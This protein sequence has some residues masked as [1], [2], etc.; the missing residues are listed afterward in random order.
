M[1]QTV[2]GV[3]FEVKHSLKKGKPT[4]KMAANRIAVVR[5][6][7]ALVTLFLLTVQLSGRILSASSVWELRSQHLPCADSSKLTLN[8]IN[9]FR[10]NWQLASK[11]IILSLMSPLWNGR[12]LNG[13][14]TGCGKAVFFLDKEVTSDGSHSVLIKVFKHARMQRFPVLT[15]PSSNSSSLHTPPT[16]PRTGFC[17][18]FP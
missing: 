18:P 10:L 2:E 5:A 6:W 15:P 17:I 16:W 11:V 4:Y 3:E 1:L 12:R 9:K 8:E 13:N 7:Q 14:A